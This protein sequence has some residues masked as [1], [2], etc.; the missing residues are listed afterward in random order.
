MEKGLNFIIDNWAYIVPVILWV[1]Q[2]LIKTQKNYD[3]LEMFIKFLGEKV[4]PNRRNDIVSL[5]TNQLDLDLVSKENKKKRGANVGRKLVTLLCL[6]AFPLLSIAQNNGNFKSVRFVN[7]L[8]STTVLP[9]NATIYYNEQSNKFRAYQNNQWVDLIGEGGSTIPSG[10]A[11]QYLALDATGTMP[12]WRTISAT[13]PITFNATTGA[14]S[15]NV[16][17]QN[18]LGRT[19]F[20]AG[21]ASS[22]PVNNGLTLAGLGLRLGGTLITGTSINGDGQSFSLIN[23]GGLNLASR[24]GVS[25]ENNTTGDLSVGNTAIG[26]TLFL[27][28]DLL[29]VTVGGSGGTAG[30]VLTSDGFNTAWQTPTSGGSLTATYIGFGDGSNVL[31]GEAA[32]SYNSTLNSVALANPAG[33]FTTSIFGGEIQ[34]DDIAGS[35]DLTINDS[36]IIATGSPSFDIGTNSSDLTLV[37]SSGNLEVSAIG[38]ISQGSYTPTVSASNNITVTGANITNWYR[39]GNSVTVYGNLQITSTGGG[40]TSTFELSLP[41]AAGVGV[42]NLSGTGIITQNGVTKLTAP[43]GIHGAST[44]AF[45]QMDAPSRTASILPYTYSYLIP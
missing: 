19:S 38:A 30:Q 10:L 3:L 39:V 23:T 22:I 2:R 16:N 24:S 9:I 13:S 36:G 8:D 29:R 42:T 45:F 7:V 15:T 41:I 43:V 28:G 14:I 27:Q 20:G 32:L 6:L 40:A 5:P 1:A 37:S 25:L 21:A 33:T 31:T 26:G 17:F 44:T 34:L 35:D 12:E 4:I 11:N 18:I